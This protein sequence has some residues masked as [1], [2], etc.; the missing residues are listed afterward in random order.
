MDLPDFVLK[1]PIMEDDDPSSLIEEPNK[2]SSIKSI[3][4]LNLDRK[5]VWDIREKHP[6]TIEQ[7]IIPAAIYYECW[8]INEAI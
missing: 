2:I 3:C 5:D 4:L 6:N 8:I 1:S 7:A